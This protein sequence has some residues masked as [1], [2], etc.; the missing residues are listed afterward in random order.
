M[1]LLRR[2]NVMWLPEGEKRTCTEETIKKK[3][4]FSQ[5]EDRLG[6]YQLCNWAKLVKTV[7]VWKSCW[8]FCIQAENA[9]DCQ[10]NFSLEIVNSKRQWNN[11]EFCSKKSLWPKYCI[12][13]Q[14]LFMCKSNRKALWE[15]EEIRKQITNVLFLKIQ[16]NKIFVTYW[17]MHWNEELMNEKDGEIIIIKKKAPKWMLYLPS[18]SWVDFPSAS[19]AWS[20]HLAMVVS[21]ASLVIINLMSTPVWT[22]EWFERA[23]LVVTP[24]VGLENSLGSCLWISKQMWGNS[25][26]LNFIITPDYVTY[27]PLF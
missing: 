2:L 21:M 11:T 23:K 17:G 3:N 5:A 10:L 12:S 7:H 13:V 14:R 9:N 24:L 20:L 6:S 18:V 1:N 4:Q 25:S 16:I 15:M 8:N 26:P 22:W 19:V 27:L